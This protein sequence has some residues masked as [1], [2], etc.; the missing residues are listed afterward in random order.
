MT[1]EII[2]KLFESITCGLNRL[3]ALI[4]F[5]T[6]PNSIWVDLNAETHDN[7]FLLAPR[8]LT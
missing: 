8:S 2:Y 6:A 1:Y 4:V 7:I 3:I 5:I